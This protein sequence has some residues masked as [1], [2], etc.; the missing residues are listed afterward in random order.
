[1]RA[2]PAAADA[3][4]VR[5]AA[6]L[7][8]ALGS[9]LRRQGCELTP[10]ADANEGKNEL[11]ISVIDEPDA[12]ASTG[13]T[14]LARALWIVETPLRWLLIG[15]VGLYRLTISPLLPPTCRFHPSCSAYGLESLKVHGAAKG[16]LL[17]AWRVLRCNPWNLGGLDPVP[18]RG[19][20]RP[21][22]N[23]DGTPRTPAAAESEATHLRW[24]VSESSADS[25]RMSAD[26]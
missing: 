6:D 21:E 26:T 8:A 4:S 13:R 20:W 19:A 12:K 25:R 18:P 7:E 2:L 15:V 14:G 10:P 5:L 24:R 1:M 11:P 17:T 23:P 22:I 3:A 16:T 9:A